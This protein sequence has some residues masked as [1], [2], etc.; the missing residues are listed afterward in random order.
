MVLSV[1]VYVV[2]LEIRKHVEFLKKLRLHIWASL[3][4]AQ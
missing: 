2:I 1:T 3:S 4:R